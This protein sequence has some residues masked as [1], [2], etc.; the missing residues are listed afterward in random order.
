MTHSTSLIRNAAVLAALLALAACGKPAPGGESGAA[1]ASGAQAAA[2]ARQLAAADVLTTRVA[3]LARLLPFT[4]TLNAL[5]SAEV[6]AQADGTVQQVLVRE[7]EQVTRGQLLAR[8][9]SEALQQ[10][11]NEQQ[12]QLANDETRLKLARLKLDKQR[13]LLQQGFISKYAFDE[14]ES[15]YQVRAGEVAARR[16]Q[17]ARARKSLSESEVRSPMAGTV[18]A[19]RT[20]PGE[21]A[22]RNQ[23]LFGIADLAELEGVASVPARLVGQLKP[24][25]QARFAVEGVDGQFNATLAR[26]NPVANAATRTFNVY[27][28]VDNRDGKLKA[29]QFAKGGVVLAE[30]KDAISLPQAALHDA[31]GSQPWL[32]AVRG[33]RLLRQPVQ[34]LLQ[35]D[36]ERQVAVR[37]IAAGETVLA[38]P[39]LGL[40]AGDA[41]SLPQR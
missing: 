6:A 15:D 31:D 41:V 40:K 29:G 30:V 8:I 19:R 12:A 35:A 26:I 7:G 16:S 5:Q 14:I 9:D 27:L 2:P 39:L 23:K 3:P 10:Q 36:S 4:A 25:Q 32:L 22:A 37:G 24:G 28:R 18:Y 13:E 21:Q 34:V 11:L 1:A 38:A 20:Q 17:L 33:G